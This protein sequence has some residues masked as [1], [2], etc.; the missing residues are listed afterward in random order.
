MAL[1]FM[2]LASPLQLAPLGF[3]FV[4]KSGQ[5]FALHPQK[6]L[7]FKLLETVDRELQE[8]SG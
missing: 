8:G 7:F 4:Q 6:N 1:P 5:V 3:N 2:P